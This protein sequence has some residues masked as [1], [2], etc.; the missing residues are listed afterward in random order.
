MAGAARFFI[1]FRSIL[2]EVGA[3]W[4]VIARVVDP[5][6]PV[7]GNVGV[8]GVWDG[9]NRSGLQ[10]RVRNQIYAI[11]IYEDRF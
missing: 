3:I 4:G 8:F 11:Q 6:T 7:L 5:K 2:S 1:L 9:V 10:L